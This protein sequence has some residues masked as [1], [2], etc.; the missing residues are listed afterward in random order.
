MQSGDGRHRRDI[1]RRRQCRQH[2][3]FEQDLKEDQA[4]AHAERLQEA[5]SRTRSKTAISSVLTMP[6]AMKTN[7]THS[8]IDEGLHEVVDR[9]GERRQLAPRTDV[10][11]G[12]RA[13]Q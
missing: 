3:G 12:R 13:L 1:R 9:G 5:D 11:I 4:R 8:Q 7:I 6:I 10:E 2:G